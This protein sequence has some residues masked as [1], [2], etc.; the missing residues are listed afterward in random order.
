MYLS[1]NNPQN[2][3][4]SKIQDKHK[5]LKY[6]TWNFETM[7]EVLLITN[8]IQSTISEVVLINNTKTNIL[9]DNI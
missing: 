4:K 9:K 3:L 7:N 1:E 6:N 2:L 8:L 5:I